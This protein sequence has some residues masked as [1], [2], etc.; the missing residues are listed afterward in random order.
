M[1]SHLDE[2]G[3]AGTA[4]HVSRHGFDAARNV[5]ALL[6]S[7]TEVEIALSREELRHSYRPVT[8]RGG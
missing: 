4:R 3:D 8:D 5:G 2:R 1:V 7:K 6:T